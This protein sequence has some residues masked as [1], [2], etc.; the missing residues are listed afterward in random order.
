MLGCAT[1]A[2]PADAL[3]LPAARSLPTSARS[4]GAV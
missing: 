3:L 1:A 4:T 2:L